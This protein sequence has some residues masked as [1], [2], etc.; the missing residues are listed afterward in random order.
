MKK[1]F[2]EVFIDNTKYC[3]HAGTAISAQDTNSDFFHSF[4]LLF[5]VY[6]YYIPAKT[7]EQWI[8]SIKFGK[9]VEFYLTK[10]GN[11]SILFFIKEESIWNKIYAISYLFIR[12][13][14]RFIP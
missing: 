12:T 10:H 5:L 7:I 9:I 11:I 14:T 4:A 1:T 13:Y 2:D 3:T 8:Y 6:V